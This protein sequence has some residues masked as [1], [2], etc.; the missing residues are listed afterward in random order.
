MNNQGI[1]MRK[2]SSKMTAFHKKLFPAMWFGFLAFFMVSAWTADA[3]SRDRWVFLFVPLLMGVLGFVFMRR[4]LW[5]LADEVHDCGDALLIRKGGEQERIPLS[6]I[7]NVSATVLVNPPR[8]TLRL[9]NPGRFGTEVAFM[10]LTHFSLNPFKKSPIA[11]DLIVRVD[12]AR[13]RVG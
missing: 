5:D 13:R 9:V 2:I 7:M 12:R 10:P 6:G 1:T 8:I 11:D 4:L 3:F